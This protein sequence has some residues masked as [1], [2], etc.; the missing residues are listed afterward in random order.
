MASSLLVMD[1]MVLI[2]K[3]ICPIHIQNVILQKSL[4]LGHTILPLLT[5]FYQ[6]CSSGLGVGVGVGATDTI[7]IS[8]CCQKKIFK[9]Q[10][11]FYFFRKK[12]CQKKLLS[13]V[14]ANWRTSTNRQVTH[15]KLSELCNFYEGFR[16]NI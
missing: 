3:L 13:E 1:I 2:R 4:F 11:S 8:G 6:S 15:V 12:A 14:F 7:K 9:W 5:Q 10:A 16:R